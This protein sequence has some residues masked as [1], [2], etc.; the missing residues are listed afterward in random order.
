MRIIPATRIHEESLRFDDN[1]II[2]DRNGV[3]YDAIGVNDCEVYTPYATYCGFTDQITSATRLDSRESGYRRETLYR[4][5]KGDFANVI[6][7]VNISGLIIEK[8]PYER[9]VEWYQA[10]LPE[11]PLMWPGATVGSV[12]GAPRLYAPCG[13]SIIVVSRRLGQTFVVNAYPPQADLLVFTEPNSTTVDLSVEDTKLIGW[14]TRQ[15]FISHHEQVDLGYRIVRA[16]RDQHLKK[17]CDIP[18]PPRDY[19]F[20]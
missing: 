4:T 2:A 15:E 11:P 16:I 5:P 1:G 12:F 6:D 7:L 3:K 9:V 20:H 18:L 17:M 8:L 13:Y 14:C 19:L 10:G